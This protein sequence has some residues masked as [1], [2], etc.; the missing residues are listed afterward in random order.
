MSIKK[1]HLNR[2]ENFQMT[3]KCIAYIANDIERNFQ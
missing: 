2:K 1:G 3:S